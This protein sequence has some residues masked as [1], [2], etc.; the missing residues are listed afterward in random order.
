M[1]R[2]ALCVR[3]CDERAAGSGQEEPIRNRWSP[4]T[5]FSGPCLATAALPPPLAAAAP[6]HIAQ[7][8]AALVDTTLSTTAGLATPNLTAAS[9]TVASLALDAEPA[10]AIATSVAIAAAAAAANHPSNT[11]VA[12]AVATSVDFIAATTTTDTD[13]NTDT[14]AATASPEHRHSRHR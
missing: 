2:A 9:L 7:L 8:I 13:T 1:R 11:A 3:R 10:A 4:S 6:D 14:A 12:V 5:P